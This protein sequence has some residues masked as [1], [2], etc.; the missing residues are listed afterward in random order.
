M[1]RAED[2]DAGLEREQPAQVG[3][4]AMAV[5]DD[6]DPDPLRVVT[7]VSGQVGGY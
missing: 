4:G 3:G 6:D 1:R 2:G 5:V 7:L